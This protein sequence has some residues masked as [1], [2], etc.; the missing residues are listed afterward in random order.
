MPF[1][2]WGSLSVADHVDTAALVANVL[3]YDR[4]IIPVMTDQP[5]RDE[6]A[7]W[8]SHGWHP[9]LQAK[10]LDQLKELA[11]RRPWNAE[12]RKTF[13]TRAAELAAEQFDADRFDGYG[14]T[15]MILAQEQVAEK[16]TG[17]Q[18]VQVIAAYNSTE[19]VKQDFQL[20][21]AHDPLSA[22]ALLLTRR[23]A[24]PD[25]PD[26][27]EALRLAIKLSRDAEFRSKRAALFD[28]QEATVSKGISPEAAV[29]YIAEMSTSYN[30]QIKKACAKVRW[31]LAFTVCGIG[32]G[33][34]TGGVVAAAAAAALSLVQFAMFDSKP[35]IE[36]DSARPAAMFH[37]VEARVG[38]KLAATG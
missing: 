17:V 13:K 11:I 28:W 14:I 37:D 32:L 18:H 23:L 29:E 19:S 12:R 5:D 1:E 35:V 2:R 7:Y 15:R 27:E 31:K 10:R 8:V 20:N 22:Q 38:L 4:L 33:F 34:A 6:R 30:A 26:V 16:L 24:V 3:L 9:D 36:A 21:D 25:L